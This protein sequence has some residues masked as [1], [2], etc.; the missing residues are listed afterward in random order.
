MLRHSCGFYLADWGTDLRMQDYLGHR[1]PKHTAHYSRVAGMPVRG[2]V[3]MRKRPLGRKLTERAPTPNAPTARCL[4]SRS[5]WT[6]ADSHRGTATVKVVWGNT[7]K[8]P[9]VG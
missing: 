1:D 4:G 3:A 7:Q 2:A 9:P 8:K 5:E 6:R